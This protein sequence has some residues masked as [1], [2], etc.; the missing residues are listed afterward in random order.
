[1]PTA[2][3]SRQAL[4]LVTSTAVTK[5]TRLVAGPAADV[6][7]TLMDAAPALVAYYSDGSAA[8]AAD[9]YDDVREQASPRHRFTAEPV[10]N[11]RADEIRNGVAWA[12]A[13]LFLP[14]PDET[15]T[16]SRLA[17]VIQLET[18]RPYRDT[19]TTNRRRDPA[20]IG[21]QRVTAGGCKFCRMLADRGAV[22]REAT[23]R[24]ASHPNCHC[25]A[26]PVFEGQPGEEASVIQ[27]VASLKR[28]TPAQRQAL[29][30]YLAALPD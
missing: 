30:E 7:S 9:Y 4:A 6:R 21:W 20:A 1:M 5:A 14:E 11:L 16:V 18:A 29:R 28:R 25:G 23:A 26:H 24:F 10:V 2:E 3:Q 19:I 27:Y 13:P 17:N 12:T 15:L 8:L 22:Y